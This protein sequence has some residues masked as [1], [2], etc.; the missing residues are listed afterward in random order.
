[1][2]GPVG[3]WTLVPGRRTLAV[4]G[5]AG[6]DPSSEEAAMARTPQEIFQHHGEALAAGDLDEILADY[7]EDSV[8]IAPSGVSR[9][10]HQIRQ[11]YVEFFAEL[12]DA[13]LD[14]P[15]LIFEGDVLYLEWTAEASTGRVT[16]GT[17]TFVFSDDAIRVH[18]LRYTTQSRP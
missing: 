15:R 17:D 9:G 10:P 11:V 1:V 18:T 4:A 12:P 7:T 14:V 2:L 13:E 8:L 6:P 5:R 16:D 3:G